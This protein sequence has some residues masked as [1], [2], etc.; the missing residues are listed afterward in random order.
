MSATAHLM[1]A[2][3]LAPQQQDPHA[4]DAVLATYRL[5]GEP[6]AVTRTDVALEM[7]FHLR[8][9]DRGRQ[10]VDML[11]DSLLTRKA[12]KA[13]GLM[14]TRDEVQAFWRKLQDQLRAAGK[15]PE[16]F[17]AVRNT[18]EKQWLDD[19]SVTIAQERLVR[20]ELGLR[21]GEE[22]NG[23]M[24][25]LWLGEARERGDVQ[26]DPDRLPLGTA[27]KVGDQNVP[28]IDLGFLLLRTSEDFERD[29]FIRQ[30]V[31]LNR[32]EAEAEELDVRVSPTDIDQEIEARRR[33]L[34]NDPRL[35][36]VPFEKQLQAIGFT[37]E[38]LRELRTF[39]AQILL[40]KLAQAKFP[41]AKLQ[42][43][44][45]AD[46][47]RVLDLVGPK[48]RIG[49]ILTRAT[50]N[51]NQLI[52]RNRE[53]ARA[54]SEK[55]RERIVRDGFAATASIESEHAASK[56]KG[57]DVGWHRRADDG[58]PEAVLAAAFA[59]NLG[60]ISVPIEAD[61]GAYI[62]TVLDKEPM[63]A[64]EALLEQLRAHRAAEWS[65]NLLAEAQIELAGTEP[66]PA[67]EAGR[68]GSSK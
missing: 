50:D 10:G 25:R 43:E 32:I 28:L 64:D 2:L 57:G 54:H 9:Q 36:G 41:D 40:D 23:D 58:L 44:L 31:Y 35:G 4:P 21:D 47:Q 68:K 6:A 16:D 67:G 12:A 3:L 52:T 53:A 56:A 29:K 38:S 27:A 22:V 13:R 24:L 18:G 15:R 14:P 61:E 5:R 19:L 8:R 42:Q 1:F 39:R 7:A 63:P 49:V 66:T 46:R 17:A 59:L 20:Q 26:T 45:E 65:E 34:A 37:V 11:V 48:R 62:V 60:E 51:P 33:R 30:V 55:V